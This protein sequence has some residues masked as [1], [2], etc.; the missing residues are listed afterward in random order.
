MSP[1][2]RRY[3]LSTA[4]RTRTAWEWTPERDEQLKQLWA[5]GLSG[6]E[7]AG[8]LGGGVTR[9]A[10]IGRV[11]RLGLPPRRKPAAKGPKTFRDRPSRGRVRPSTPPCPELPEINRAGTVSARNEPEALAQ[12]SATLEILPPPEPAAAPGDAVTLMQLRE[13]MCRWPVGENADGRAL[14]CGAGR[15]HGS[16][17]TRHAALAY[18]PRE[19][20]RR[21][22]EGKQ[23]PRGLTA[24]WGF[25]A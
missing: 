2:P 10:V 12:G 15:G 22:A 14:F 24:G 8:A 16:Y 25:I 18:Q 19:T 9:N 17:C 11:H 20:P 4:L 6:S 7:I 13:P 3:D 21:H 1:S 5:R 23:K